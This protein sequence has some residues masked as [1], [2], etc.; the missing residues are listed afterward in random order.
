VVAS[1]QLVMILLQL[2]VLLQFLLPS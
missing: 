1:Y 2:V